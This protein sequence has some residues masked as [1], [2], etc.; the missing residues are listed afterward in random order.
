MGNQDFHLEPPAK[1]TRGI[2]SWWLLA[3]KVIPKPQHVR[4]VKREI[5]QEIKSGCKK[6]EKV[7]NPSPHRYQLPLAS[8]SP[9]LCQLKQ[10]LTAAGAMERRKEGRSVC[11]YSDK[12]CEQQG[13]HTDYNSNPKQ[14]RKRRREARDEWERE[15]VKREEMLGCIRNLPDR[16]KPVGVIWAVE[17]GCKFMVVGPNGE[18]VELCLELG[19]VL[20][21]HGDLVHAGAA[22][23]K[24]S[25]MRVHMYLH[26]Q[27]AAVPN[28]NTFEVTNFVPVCKVSWSSRD[29]AHA[30]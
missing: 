21:F 18:S 4:K 27:H 7:F 13:W 19:E 10:A 17:E 8:D 20:L 26:S 30:I 22:Y 25:N 2:P 1:R 28:G 23:P 9:L 16:D 12:G 11:L 29:R 3:G 14:S 6:L 15:R 5:E 24:Y